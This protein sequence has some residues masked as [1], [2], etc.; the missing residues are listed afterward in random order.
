MKKIIATV[1]AMVM[2]LALCTTAFAAG[3]IGDDMDKATAAAK[4]G[5]TTTVVTKIQDARADSTNSYAPLYLLTSTTKDANGNVTNTTTKNAVEMADAHGADTVYVEGSTVRYFKTATSA[6]AATVK[7]TAATVVT[8]L[9]DVKCGS[10][11]ASADDDVYVTSADVYYLG[12][13]DSNATMALV[14][15]K[16][17]MVKTVTLTEQ[18][19]AN[20]TAVPAAGTLIGVVHNY[21]A[22][23]TKVNGDESITKV[24]CTKCNS[25]FKFVDG[26]EAKAIKEF[27]VGNYAAT[28]LTS[29]NDGVVYVMKTA[30]GTTTDTKG[31]TTSP[32]TF[33]AGIAMYVG[34]ALTSV[35]GSAVVIGKKKEF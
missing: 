10:L 16:Y 31:N 1:L 30:S 17:V 20:T 29:L 5:S 13:A 19:A 25:T 3:F 11:V 7:V 9:A 33:D 24:Y 21:K 32:K 18:T 14:G 6:P 15:D 28:N 34:M 23:T 22:D 12:S 27:G 4:D 8:K 35:A 26:S 2:A